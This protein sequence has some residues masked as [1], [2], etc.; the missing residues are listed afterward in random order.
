MLA[1][2]EKIQLTIATYPGLKLLA[3]LFLIILGTMLVFEGS[4]LQ[5]DKSYTYV[6]LAFGLTLEILHILLDRQQKKAQ[7]SYMQAPNIRLN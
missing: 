7:T 2:A 4:G 1:L 5:V 6:V 3:L